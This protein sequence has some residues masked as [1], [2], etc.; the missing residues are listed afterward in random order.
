MNIVSENCHIVPCYF[1]IYC[2]IWKIEI[3]TA[4]WW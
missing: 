1:E 4:C 2:Y 3:N